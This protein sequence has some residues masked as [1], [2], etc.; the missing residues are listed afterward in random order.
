M[1]E[2]SN[3]FQLGNHLLFAKDVSRT[4]EE[5]NTEKRKGTG[6]RNDGAKVHMRPSTSHHITSHHITSHH[7]T[8]HHIHHIT[9]H[10]ITSHHITSH[11]ITS[12]HIAS[13]HITSHHITY[14]NSTH[15]RRIRSN[16]RISTPA[17][18]N[19]MYKLQRDAYDDCVLQRRSFMALHNGSGYKPAMQKR[20]ASPHQC[21]RTG[22]GKTNDSPWA[23][24]RKRSQARRN[25]PKNNAQTINIDF[26]CTAAAAKEKSEK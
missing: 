17:P 15:L 19:K 25:F 22:Q 23:E 12:H 20:Q 11:H 26:L 16:I 1:K 24:I 5:T 8:S 18:L 6:I 7:I 3:F 10:H 4:R 2:Y 14:I 9:S 13:H 21:T